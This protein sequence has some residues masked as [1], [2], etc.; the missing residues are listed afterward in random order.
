MYNIDKISKWKNSVEIKIEKILQTERI[1]LD[2][3]VKRELRKG[4][5]LISGNGAVSI[6]N[7]KG[8]SYH[9]D[10]STKISYK[11]SEFED[12]LSKLA[13]YAFWEITCPVSDIE[14]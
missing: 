14:K 8:E 12:E 4:D 2:K 10:I 7:Y 3:I 13:N 5:K 11:A 1:K 6:Y 9:Y